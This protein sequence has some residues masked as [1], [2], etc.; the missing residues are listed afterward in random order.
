[1]KDDPLSAI[2]AMPPLSASS[3]ALLQATELFDLPQETLHKSRF[4]MWLYKYFSYRLIWS[5]D[6]MDKIQNSPPW[7]GASGPHSVM[8]FGSVLNIPSVNHFVFRKFKGCTAS[9]LGQIPMLRYLW[10]WGCEDVSGKNMKKMVEKGYCVGLVCDGIAGI[11]KG[12]VNNEV[13]CILLV[14]E[15]LLY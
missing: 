5:D 9:V 4:S 3:T 6:A 15:Y 11:F 13:N 2:P 1:M 12:D 7:V 10:L 8:P 14:Q